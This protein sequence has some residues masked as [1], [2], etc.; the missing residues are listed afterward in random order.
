MKNKFRNFLQEEQG[1]LSILILAFLLAGFL[2]LMALT[3]IS[4][5]YLAKRAL[6]QGTEAA[7]QR[8]VRNLNF[9]K[10][11]EKQSLLSKSDPGIPIDCAKGRKDS[12][13][14]M[15]SWITLRNNEGH[16]IGRTNLIDVEV[17]EF[18]C[19]GYEI[20]LSTLARIK[21]P[22]SVPI[23]GIDEV[24]IRSHVS[25]IAERKITSNFYGIDIN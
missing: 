5:V 8:G 7:T 10:Y 11:Y 2:V 22:F 17:N 25:S 9:E 21:L 12:L 23:F 19:D 1:S 13:E 6:T 16:T 14:A 24:E 20:T 4:S 3:D 15:D 18:Q